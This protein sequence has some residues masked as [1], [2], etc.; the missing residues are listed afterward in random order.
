M[1]YRRIVIPQVGVEARGHTTGVVLEMIAALG[2]TADGRVEN[3]AERS[4]HKREDRGIGAER[5]A[6]DEKSR[7]RNRER[8]RQQLA[9]LPAA[10]NPRPWN[11][12]RGANVQIAGAITCPGA[13]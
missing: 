11:R 10:C 3:R 5:L 9:Q 6:S 12:P 8:A 7:L 1:T 4:D 13:S 2:R